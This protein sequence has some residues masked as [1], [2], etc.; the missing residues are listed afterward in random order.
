MSDSTNRPDLIAKGVGLIVVTAFLISSQD[1]VFKAFAGE[2]V[3]WQI[4][5]LRGV[6]ALPLL[7]ILAGLQ[8]GIGPLLGQ[9]LSRW[10]L[11]RAACF[12]GTFLLFYAALPFISLAT[13]GAGMYMAPIFVALMAARVLREPVGVWGWV[14]VALGF[15]GVLVMLRPGSDG[16]S[17]WSLVPIL[18]AVLYASGHVVTRQH[19][20]T[21]PGPA[22]SLSLNA[23]MV[24]AGL[25]ITAGLL[26]LPIGALALA[27]PYI[28]GPWTA[29]AGRDWLVL[30][31]LAVFAVTV[32]ALLANAYKAAP[33][34]IIATFEYSYLI[35]AAIWDITVF[36]LTPTGPTLAG[37][38]MIAAAGI[39][40]LQRGKG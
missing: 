33:P 34:A 22:L 2:M 1:V 39:L 27:E 19:C 10:S 11:I 9:A 17:G 7:L 6:F 28:F 29:M 18:A 8:T 4:F 13:A 3:L 26:V 15:A 23:M 31:V 24:V 36:G 25:V 38:A 5:A 37:M 35:F 40:S 21:L 32:A 12:T 20:Q 14:A 16:F 30:L